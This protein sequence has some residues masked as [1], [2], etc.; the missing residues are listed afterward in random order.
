MLH[1]AKQKQK[2]K[3]PGSLKNMC[4]NKKP[5]FLTQSDIEWL[6]QYLKEQRKTSESDLFTREELDLEIKKILDESYSNRDLSN[7]L[8]EKN[9][10]SL[11]LFD[12]MKGCGLI[13]PKNEVIERN[14]ILAERV[15]KLKRENEERE[16]KAMTQNIDTNKKH[17]PEDSVSFQSKCYLFL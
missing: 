2:N 8:T 14:P 15:E 3:V 13:L 7:F 11:Y 5:C 16:Y 9:K 10:N 4:I 1:G 6:N 12:L 17:F